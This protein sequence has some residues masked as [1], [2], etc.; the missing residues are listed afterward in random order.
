M[1]DSSYILNVAEEA[2][3]VL[4]MALLS[5]F[6]SQSLGCVV[7][8][9]GEPDSSPARSTN[10]LCSAVY[11]AI[12]GAERS[13]SVVHTFEPN[14]NKLSSSNILLSFLIGVFELGNN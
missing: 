11:I 12:T 13:T 1:G 5:K 14:N 7:H 2:K 8:N 6:S 4:M 9:A 3:A 10:I